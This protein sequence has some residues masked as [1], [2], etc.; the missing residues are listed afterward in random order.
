MERQ[1]LEE[2]ACLCILFQ[3]NYQC[4]LFQDFEGFLSGTNF[5]GSWIPGHGENI[6]KWSLRFASRQIW[7]RK[8]FET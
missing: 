6:E 8:T 4:I 3:I 7:I 1:I 2:T 5:F